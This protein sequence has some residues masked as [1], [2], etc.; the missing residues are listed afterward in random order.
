VV[1]CPPLPEPVY[2]DREMWEKIVLNL[3]SNAL[4]STFDGEIRVS[5]GHGD[6]SAARV[7]DTGT[8]ISEAI[9][10]TCSALPAHRR[11]ARRSHE[12]S[13]IGLA[14][15]QELV[16]MHG[17]SIAWK[18]RSAREPRSPVTLPFGQ[19]TCRTAAWSAEGEPR[20]AAGLGRGLCAGGD[21]LAAGP[22]P[23]QKEVPAP[24]PAMSHGNPLL[25]VPAAD[26]K[27][28]I[29]LVDDNADMR[30]YVI[31]LLGW[32]FNVVQAE[33]GKAGARLPAAR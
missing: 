13:G 2:V 15:V 29:L 30:E 33:N 26:R 8:G 7:S 20:C 5:C 16:E 9:C 3:L 27:P 19:S 4:K 10:R 17:G 12:G 21:G 23:A 18:A 25:A 24:L 6:R 32:R 1:D 28:E 14:L 11:R 22:R 31:G